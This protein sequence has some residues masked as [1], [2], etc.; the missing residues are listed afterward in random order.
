MQNGQWARRLGSAAVAA[1]LFTAAG[2]SSDSPSNTTTAATGSSATVA[3]TSA[4]AP[5]PSA[6]SAATGAGGALDGIRVPD[7]FTAV[8]VRPLSDPTFPFKGSDGKFHVVYDLE[9]TNATQLPATIEKLDVVDAASPTT[10]IDSYSG[11]R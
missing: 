4:Q 9:L 10:V 2:C 8:A 1:A 6:G 3:T 11:T 7:A 5:A